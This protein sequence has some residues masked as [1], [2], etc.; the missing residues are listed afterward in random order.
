MTEVRKD[1]GVSVVVP[2]YNSAATLSELCRRIRRVLTDRPH[3]VIMVDDGSTDD[4]LG[5]MSRL[6]VRVVALGGNRGQNAAI[7]AG[8]AH[9]TQPSSCVLDADLQD[10]PEAIPELLSCL[11]S[12]GAHVVFSSRNAAPRLSSHVFRRLLWLLFPSLPPHACLCFA[13]DQQ[14]RDTLLTAA[15]ERDYLPAIIGALNFTTAEVIVERSARLAG[16]S[17]YGRV[18]RV[19]YAIHMLASA[20]YQRWKITRL[21]PPDGK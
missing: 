11:E 17:A 21:P 12:S 10:P 6:G 3:D 16:R 1:L 7:L 4:S 14:A 5:V 19:R 18:K 15:S 9:A 13:I 2:V 8:L 20:L